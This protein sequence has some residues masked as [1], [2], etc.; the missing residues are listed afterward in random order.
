MKFGCFFGGQRP[1]HHEQYGEGG[2]ENPNAV[3]RTDT[4]VYQDILKGAR[5]AEELGFD[6]VWITEHAF[7]EH[8]IISSPHSLLA[9]IAAQTTRV[10]VGVAV[11]VVPWHHPIR[12]AQDLATI[13]VISQGRLIIGAGRGYQ[14]REFDGYGVDIS[15]SRERF[16]EGMDIAI[17]AWSQ[18]RFSY[19]GK[20]YNIPDVMVLPKPV[21]KPHPPIWMAVT[22]SP[23]SLDIAVRNRWSLI[24]V[25]GL[26]PG[27]DTE[28]EQTLIGL[29]H[30]KMMDNGVAPEDISVAVVRNLYVA[31]SNEE[32]LELM[33]PR[34]LWAADINAFLRAPVAAMAGKLRGYEHYGQDPFTDTELVARRM[35]E[36]VGTPDKVSTAIGDLQLKKITHLFMNLDAG[37]LPYE[38]V[39]SS[40]RLFA[41]KVMPS[42]N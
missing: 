23:E 21:Q 1:Q 42:F 16:V 28:E 5:L 24:T 41:A 9:A 7:S 19:E 32:A 38:H 15:E 26:S 10:K 18:E 25:G 12:M 2:K 14:K 22:Q 36:M 13:D 33:K 37:G 34:L 27:A 40:L 11:T 29:Y 30:S 31:E 8:G 35:Q 3:F 39:E 4:E 17:R 20:F 6:S